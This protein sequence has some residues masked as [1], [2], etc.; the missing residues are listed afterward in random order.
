M[1]YPPVGVAMVQ[2]DLGT[3]RLVCRLLDVLEHVVLRDHRAAGHRR[4]GQSLGAGDHVGRHVE[5]D[6]GEGLAQS[7]EASDHL[8]EDQ[9]DV[10]L[11][12]DLSD[13]LQVAH[14]RRKHACTTRPRLDD[15]RQTTPEYMTNTT[16]K[17][18]IESRFVHTHTELQKGL[19]KTQDLD[20]ISL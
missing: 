16:S 8:V 14:G 7:A 18:N 17:Y 5:L 6:R 19:K 20:A 2:F 4:V 15:L 1:K 10:V 12:A 13:A 9:Q 3:G 11:V